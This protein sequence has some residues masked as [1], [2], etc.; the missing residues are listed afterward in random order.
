MAIR[1]NRYSGRGNRYQ[2]DHGKFYEDLRWNGKL[3]QTIALIRHYYHFTDEYIM[4]KSLTW[5]MDAVDFILRKE[6]EARRWLIMQAQLS[7]TPMEKQ[8]ARASS[9]Q[10]RKITDMLTQQEE[11][12]DRLQARENLKEFER[13]KGKKDDEIVSSF[14]I[15]LDPSETKAGITKAGILG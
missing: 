5:R 8:S 10:F 9:K 12:L 13:G 2:S 14:K 11:E 1:G 4:S 3:D 15:E 6:I 7:H